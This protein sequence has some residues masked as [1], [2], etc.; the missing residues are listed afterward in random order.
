M[1]CNF[2]GHIE[3]AITTMIIKD[4]EIQQN[5][6]FYYPGSIISN[7]RE[8]DEDVKH[9]INAGWLKWKLLLEFFL[10]ANKIEERFLQD[11]D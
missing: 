7:D 8:I 4:H 10:N 5:D 11:I 6:S 3:R 1:V 9:R 2:S